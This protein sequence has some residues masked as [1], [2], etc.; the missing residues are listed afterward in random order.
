MTTN[1]TQR[2]P[3]RY[4]GKARVQWDPER[5]LDG[6]GGHRKR[7]EPRRMSRTRA[8]QIGLSV[9]LS[10]LYVDSIISIEDVTY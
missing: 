6:P 3:M 5:D 10:K 1:S 4:S 9:D 8:I 2:E 7:L